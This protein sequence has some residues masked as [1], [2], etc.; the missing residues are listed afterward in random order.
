MYRSKDINALEINALIKNNLLKPKL[1]VDKN[2]FAITK[3][4]VAYHVIEIIM[5]CN[6]F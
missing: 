2:H 4:V 3:E 6:N 5:K 1:K